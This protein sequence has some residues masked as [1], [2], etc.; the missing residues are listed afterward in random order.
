VE[1]K[2]EVNF[3]R[4]EW[5]IL[6]RGKAHTFLSR[7]FLELLIY[8]CLDPIVNYVFIFMTTVLPR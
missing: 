8:F 3:C 4:V 5:K 7:P 2:A 1:R 6:Q